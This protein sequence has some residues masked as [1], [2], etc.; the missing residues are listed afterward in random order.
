MTENADAEPGPGASAVAAGAPCGAEGTETA[1][2]E[3]G[4]GASA[5]AAGAP[6]GAEGDSGVV[7]MAL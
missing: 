5:V 7:D 1:D 6:C 3:P 4:P 2:A